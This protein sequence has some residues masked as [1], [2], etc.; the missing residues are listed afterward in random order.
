MSNRDHFH[1]AFIEK[2]DR[3]RTDMAYIRR[4]L[5]EQ[6]LYH[7]LGWLMPAILAAFALIAVLVALAMTGAM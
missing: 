1:R 7:D 4:D 2:N 5:K 3:D 6:Q